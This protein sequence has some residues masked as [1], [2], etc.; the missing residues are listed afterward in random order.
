VKIMYG[1]VMGEA[2]GPVAIGVMLV[3]IVAVLAGLA[4]GFW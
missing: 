2:E 4:R 3:V 1:L